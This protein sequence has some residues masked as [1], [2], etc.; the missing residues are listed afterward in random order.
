MVVQ[1]NNLKM[2]R[3]LRYLHSA[4]QCLNKMIF[5]DDVLLKLINKLFKI[6]VMTIK[7]MNLS[8]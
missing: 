6:R 8:V 4:T 1:T 2:A 5:S 7:P 3:L